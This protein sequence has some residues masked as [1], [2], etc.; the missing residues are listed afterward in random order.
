MKA[1]T[2]RMLE[3]SGIDAETNPAIVALCEFA[4][5]RSGID[6][7]DY[8]SDWRDR[9]GRQAYQDEVKEISNQLRRFREALNVAAVEGVTDADVAE[10][11]HAY[12]G[13]LEWVTTTRN[14]APEPCA[15]CKVKPGRLHLVACTGGDHRIEG[16]WSYCTGQYF[17]TEYRNAAATLLEYAIRRV[18]RA[19]PKE[20]AER[21][22]TIAQLKA[23]AE[24]NGS[25]WFER[26]TMRWHGTTIQS[27]IIQGAYFITLDKRGFEESD[28][29]GYTV[30]TFDNDGSPRSTRFGA[31]GQRVGEFDTKGE[32]LKVL[33][34]YLRAKK[35]EGGI[36]Q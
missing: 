20:T 14:A 30:R 4:A 22:T 12:S 19:R 11:P 29:Y 25:C 3:Q 15:S 7:R 28:G 21:I 10:A 26:S 31:R 5:Q 33:S 18:R 17:C 32:A 13:R 34:D 23:L 36:Q 35:T 24:R 2:Q 27:G 8:F 16:Y 9:N 1:L 6:S